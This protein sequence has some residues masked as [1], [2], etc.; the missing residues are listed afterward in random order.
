[1][2]FARQI[3]S[4]EYQVWLYSEVDEHAHAVHGK[5]D[6]LPGGLVLGQLDGT[7]HRAAMK[8]AIRVDANRFTGEVTKVGGL[9]YALEQRQ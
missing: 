8:P 3:V 1:M 5:V 6:V 7:G 4:I 9:V 2:P